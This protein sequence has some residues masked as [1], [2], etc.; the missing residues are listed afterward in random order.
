MTKCEWL[1]RK[2]RPGMEKPESHHVSSWP[3]MKLTRFRQ[4]HPSCA[5]G[6]LLCRMGKRC[7]RAW[8]GLSWELQALPRGYVSQ[9]HEITPKG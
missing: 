7:P 6:G 3:E 5:P 8:K 4:L 1:L 9:Q 2:S